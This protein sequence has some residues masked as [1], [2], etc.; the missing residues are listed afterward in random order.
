MCQYYQE[1]PQSVRIVDDI[2]E[3][4]DVIANDRYVYVA[5]GVAGLT[6]LP[7]Q[8]AGWGVPNVLSTF[9]AAV[10]EPDAEDFGVQGTPPQRFRAVDLAWSL[11]ELIDAV[12][13]R[14]NAESAGDSW[15]VSFLPDPL[16]AAGTGYVARDESPCWRG[17]LPVRYTLLHA[18]SPDA[19]TALGDV[20]VVFGDFRDARR[21]RAAAPR[22]RTPSASAQV[23]HELARPGTARLTVHALTG[24][25]VRVL[26]DGP[27]T[28]G[29]HFATWDGRDGRGREMPAGGYVVR[30][31]TEAGAGAVKAVL[32]R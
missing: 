18:A 25:L 27:Q 7:Q 5:C 15:D 21:A 2:A 1:G 16:V 17:R 3:A 11:A 26:A 23:S 13:L 12:S 24:A 22:T 8:C 32:V 30:I 31:A 6:V 4:L 14:L 20:T 10:S 19:W 29:A 28:A 9:T